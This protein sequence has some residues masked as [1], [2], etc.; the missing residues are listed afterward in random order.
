MFSS[1]RGERFAAV[2]RCGTVAV[3]DMVS[4][5]GIPSVASVASVTP[6]SRHPWGGTGC[7]S[8]ACPSCGLSALPRADRRD[9]LPAHNGRVEV[10]IAHALRRQPES[11]VT[12]CRACRCATGRPTTYATI[13]ACLDPDGLP[14]VDRDNL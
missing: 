14:A 8:S 4:I 2:L 11:N 5:A 13:W 1:Q 6:G 7:V 12:A 3:I 9:Q 10:G